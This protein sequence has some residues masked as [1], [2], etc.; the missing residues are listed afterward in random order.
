VNNTDTPALEKILALIEANYSNENFSVEELA[1][2]MGLSRSQLH[3]K[4]KVV[5]VLSANQLIRK[6]RLDKAQEL[7]LK[8]DRTV[9]EIAFE[10]GFSSPS[11]FTSSFTQHFGYPPGEARLRQMNGAKNGISTSKM[12]AIK[13]DTRRILFAGISILLIAVLS[14]TWIFIRRNSTVAEMAQKDGN[15]PSIVVLPFRNLNTNQ[16]NEYFS[17]G[18]IQAINR[19]LS[20][21]DGLRVVSLSSAFHYRNSN[22]APGQISRELSVSYLLEGSIQRVEN[23]VRIEIQ[24]VDA[25]NGRQVWAQNY[26]REINDIFQTQ[27]DIAEKVIIALKSTLSTGEKAVLSEKITGNPAAYD[28]YL[29]GNY[30]LSS[31]SRNGTRKAIEYF[32]QAIILD[33]GFASAYSGIAYAYCMM[34][35]IYVGELTALEAMEQAKPYIDKAIELQPDLDEAHALSGFYELYYNWNFEAAE[36]QYQRAIVNNNKEALALYADFLNFIGRDSDAYKIALRL[37]QTDPYYPNSRIPFTLYYLGKHKEATE[38]TESR[39]KQF[40]NYISYDNY[41]FLMLNTGN[42]T[43]AIRSFEK[44]MEIEGFRYPR[45]LGWMGASH[46]HRGKTELARALIEELKA[47]DTHAGSVDFFIAVIYA[48]LKDKDSVIHWLNE[49]YRNH[50]MEIPWLISEPQ[51]YWLHEEP[52]FKKLVEKLDF[53]KD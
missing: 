48:A 21:I 38:F 51:F 10:V 15:S 23:Q 4:L 35:S 5:N 49:A 9:S 43:E 18:V 41:G 14:L 1:E 16:E 52:E 25:A 31:Y 7:L 47:K 34:S 46:A 42:Y 17:V 27:S 24:L 44:A 26:D 37:N 29:K 8:S 50:E 3:R 20:Q 11:Y 19:Y 45:G 53:P 40:Q 30:E 2:K 36:K 32:N 28:L 33:P 12:P 13:H 22:K 39:L 6:Y